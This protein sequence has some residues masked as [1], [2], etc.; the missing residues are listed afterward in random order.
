MTM[1]GFIDEVYLVISFYKT[2]ITPINDALN[3][4]QKVV[5]PSYNF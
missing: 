3:K 4:A 1:K 5:L 2:Y